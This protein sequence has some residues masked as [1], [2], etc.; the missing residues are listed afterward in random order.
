MPAEI[1]S[2][3]P[4]PSEPDLDDASVGNVESVST[5]VKSADKAASGSIGAVFLHS[6]QGGDGQAWSV[7]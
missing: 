5:L 4:R 3:D 6:P 7:L 2:I 1:G